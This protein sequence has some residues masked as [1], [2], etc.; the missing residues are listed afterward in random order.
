MNILI[1]EDD[2]NKLKQLHS[3]IER[4]R[5][6]A[7]VE[8]RRSY[9][10][11]LAAIIEGGHDLVILDVSMTTYD[12][13]PTESGGRKRPFAGREILRHMSRR[14]IETPVVVVTQFPRFGEGDESMSLKELMAQLEQSAFSN[15][16]GTIYYS[17]E[18]AN[19]ESKM[20]EILKKCK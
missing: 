9:Q 13:S 14:N 5:N 10:S 16:L 1:I 15:Y 17:A 20:R 18:E 3:F 11:G 6:D 12:Q 2:Q 7:Q 8:V 19:W 4:E